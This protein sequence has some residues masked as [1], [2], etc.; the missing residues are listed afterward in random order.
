MT[1][2]EQTLVDCLHNPMACGGPSVINEAWNEGASKINQQAL[3][4]ILAGVAPVLRRRTATM[5]ERMGIPLSS[6]IAMLLDVDPEPVVPLLPGFA[7]G[8]TRSSWGVLV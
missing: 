5:M 2:I 3:A 7:S 1:S 6:Q 4:K 8:T